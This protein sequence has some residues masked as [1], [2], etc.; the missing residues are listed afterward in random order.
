M[1]ENIKAQ[2][3]NSVRDISSDNEKLASAWTIFLPILGFKLNV[4]SRSIFVS[5]AGAFVLLN[6]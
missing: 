5:E 1:M 6:P 2:R 3:E 4:K